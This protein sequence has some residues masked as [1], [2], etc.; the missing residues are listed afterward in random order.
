[1]R[2]IGAAYTACYANATIT[3]IGFCARAAS[4]QDGLNEVKPIV[5]L[6][7]SPRDDAELMPSLGRFQL[8]AGKQQQ[9]RS[10]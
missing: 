2:D 5:L 10:L 9:G 4:P 1:M 7:Q 8:G 6:R 3:G